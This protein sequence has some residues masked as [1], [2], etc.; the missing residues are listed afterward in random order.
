V[1]NRSY[2]TELVLIPEPDNAMDRNAIL[3]SRADDMNCDPGYITLFRRGQFCPL[4]ERG[5]TFRAQL[6]WINRERPDYLEAYCYVFQMTEPL[7]KR[8][9]VRRGAPLYKGWRPQE[10]E[11]QS[12]G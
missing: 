4:I 10:A 5:A 3:V 11:E 9:P 12:Q 1:R 7:L 2:G 8:R 6:Y